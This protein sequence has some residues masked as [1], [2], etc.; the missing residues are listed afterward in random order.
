MASMPYL[1]Y[2]DTAMASSIKRLAV[3]G[4]TGSIGRQ[5]LAAVR[6]GKTVALANK[7]ALV[8][9]GGFVMAEAKQHRAQVLPVDSEHSAIWQCLAGERQEGFRIVLTASGG[10][11]RG[12][13]AAQLAEGPAESAL[14]QPS[15]R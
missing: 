9:A 3:L 7:E 14:A 2:D 11:F 15:G 8:M 5:T 13:T 10:P 6:A 12:Y 1:L 4:S